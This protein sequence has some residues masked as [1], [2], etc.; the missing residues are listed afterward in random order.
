MKRILYIS[1]ACGENEYK[2]I[3]KDCQHFPAQQGQ[4]FNKLMAEGF[5]QNG[6]EVDLLSSRPIIGMKKQRYKDK[7]DVEKGVKY[8]YLKFLNYRFI[9]NFSLRKSAKKFVKNWCKQNPN[10]LMFFD[11]LTPIYASVALKICKKYKIKVVGI[12][13][14]LPQDI[15]KKKFNIIES[16]YVKQYLNNIKQCDNYVF[17]ADQ[18]KEKIDVTNKPYIVI[19]GLCDS[20]IKLDKTKITRE[21]TILYTGSIHKRYGIKMLIDA[22]SKINN[23]NWKLKICGIGDM[24]SELKNISHENIEYLGSIPNQE[25]C[26]LQKKVKLLI[27]PRPTNEDF[28][29]YSFPSKNIEYMTSGTPMLTTVLPSMPKEYYD[30]VYL[31]KNESVDGFA[32]TISEII[33][34]PDDELEK[35][36]ENAQKFILIN[37]NNKVQTKKIIEFLNNKKGLTT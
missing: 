31:L 27:N 25:A 36:G 19:E 6:Y 14:D 1:S 10:G 37:K 35:M 30:Y 17:L 16:Y 15:K 20:S 2:E 21:N 7:I 34:K 12:V 8:N 33:Q 29:K 3:Y 22:F 13:T 9:R 18:M 26:E 5:V 4:K 23:H 32:K 11:I 28:V 24:E